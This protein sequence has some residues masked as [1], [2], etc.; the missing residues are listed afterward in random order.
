MVMRSHGWNTESTFSPR[1]PKDETVMREASGRELKCACDFTEG[2]GWG[3]DDEGRVLRALSTRK[4]L[5]A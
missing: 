4:Q 3:V 1:S 2:V 5:F